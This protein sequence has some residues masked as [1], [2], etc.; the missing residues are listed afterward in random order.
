MKY[1]FTHN[2]KK[3]ISEVIPNQ[4]I[5]LDIDNHITIKDTGQQVTDNGIEQTSEIYG[6]ARD[7]F[8]VA[9]AQDLMLKKVSNYH[10]KQEIS[11]QTS[12]S[13]QEG[14]NS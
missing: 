4:S 1:T 3:D 5:I 10:S 8:E 14:E 13:T 7:N 9:K 11:K 6:I 12:Q 2:P